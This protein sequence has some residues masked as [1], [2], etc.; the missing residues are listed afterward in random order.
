MTLPAPP[1][2]RELY[3]SHIPALKTLINLGWGYLSPAD[4]LQKRGGTR[5][6]ILKDELVAVLKTRRFDYKGKSYPLSTNAID[7]I[8]RDLSSP[9]LNEGLLSAN[10]KIYNHLCFGITVTEFIDG[11]KHSPNIAIIDWQTIANNRFHI[12]EEMEVQNSSATG[13]RR[14][15][16]VGFVN[17]LPLLIIEA[18]QASAGNDKSKMVN[19]G[20]RQHKRNWGDDEIPQLFVY[21]Q[22][23]LSIAVD[24][25]KYGT[26]KTAA[27]FWA[28]W[29]DEEFTDTHF[30]QVKNKALPT[31][32]VNALFAR[33]TP[34]VSQHFSTLWAKEQLATAQ[35]KLLI[36]LLSPER[37]LEFVRFYILFD[38]KNNKIAARYQ[39]FFSTRAMLHRI[40][41]RNREGGRSGGVI[42][43]TTGSGKSYTMVYLCKTLL[44]HPALNNSR[45]IAITDR[46]DL[47]KQLSKTF[48]SS[49]ALT[50]KD[51]DKAKAR[52]G[53]DLAKRI[54][55]GNERIIFSIINKF[56]TASKQA[57]CYNPDDNIIVLVDEGHRSQEGE[58]HE[59]MRKALPNAAYIAFTGT[60]LLEKEKTTNKFG[61]IIHAYTMK[62]AEQD[63]AITPLLY[64]ERQPLLEVNEK[65]IDTWFDKITA[66]LSSP[67]KS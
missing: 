9:G 55:Q 7:Q 56:N 29:R 3:S 24:Q 14:P 37:L 22:L 15:D 5:E 34:E 18:K 13:N 12:S 43:H 49:G 48:F 67:A 33:H 25:A 66:E 57:E 42:W 32:V 30:N 6:V 20:I 8:V 10:E 46:Q 50:E 2:T 58:N 40:N 21:S 26:T 54:G 39:Q 31:T 23:L 19:E 61:P 44:L 36:S 52:T 17:G 47:E 28:G 4:C 41:Q 1:K 27:K 35:D 60:P 62:Q 59:L 64:E 45:I 63:K 16:I 51:F 11:K 65:A 38:K 53:K